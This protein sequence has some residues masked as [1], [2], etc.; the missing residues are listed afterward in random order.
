MRA[1]RGWG[2]KRCGGWLAPCAIHRR[3]H[4]FQYSG[5]VAAMSLG[6]IVIPF[7]AL[8]VCVAGMWFAWR[9]VGEAE[10]IDE[11][12]DK[13]QQDK[14]TSRPEPESA[15]G[16]TGLAG[17]IMML[18]GVSLGIGGIA[19]AIARAQGADNPV[20]VAA[21]WPFGFCL[22]AVGIRALMVRRRSTASRNRQP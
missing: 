3:R 7:V 22:V 14:P 4:G 1:A 6:A 5:K 16:G 9:L 2:A 12:D 10:R 17:P 21:A 15:T 13:G 8:A 18:G 20:L 11:D 19:F